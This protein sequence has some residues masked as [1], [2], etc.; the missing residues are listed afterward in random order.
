MTKPLANPGKK[1][2]PKGKL[3]GPLPQSVRE[4]ISTSQ[5]RRWA[6]PQTHA[7]VRNSILQSYSTGKLARRKVVWDEQMDETLKQLRSSIKFS[8]FRAEAK[9]KIGVSDRVLM[10]RL[11]FL[12]LVNPVISAR[13]AKAR[14]HWKRRMKER[15][16][17]K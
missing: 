4:R 5:K 11:K 17:L 6:D 12:G 13:S 10:A 15:G 9:A 16:S 7:K 1:G 8:S 3:K 14:A 2:W